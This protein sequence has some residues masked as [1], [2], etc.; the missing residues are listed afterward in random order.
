MR[1]LNIAL[2]TAIT[3][4]LIGAAVG[5]A[6][7]WNEGDGCMMPP[8]TIGI[9]SA[10]LYGLGG[11]VLGLALS[12]VTVVAERRRLMMVDTISRK[13]ADLRDHRLSLLRP[14]IPATNTLLRASAVFEPSASEH[15][16]RIPD[17]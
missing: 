7:H 2:M 1:S 6:L 3:C 12:P 8:P 5:G 15:L 4:A 14:S 11:L 13:K 16:L 9:L 17:E 10:I